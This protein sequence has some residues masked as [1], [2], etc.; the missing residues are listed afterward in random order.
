MANGYYDYHNSTAYTP[1][2]GAGF[3]VQQARNSRYYVNNGTGV[4]TPTLRGRSMAYQF[5][6][7]VSYEFETGITPM[8]VSL[9]YRYFTSPGINTHLRTA[10][11]KFEFPNDSHNL[12]LGGRIYF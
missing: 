10:P 7:G 12:E 2:L 9:G 5:M 6:T 4:A 3:G 8:A 11:G 1:Y